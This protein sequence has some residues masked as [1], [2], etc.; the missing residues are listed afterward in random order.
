MRQMG[1]YNGARSF[2]KPH[3][4]RRYGEVWKSEYVGV[5]AQLAQAPAVF[6]R[7]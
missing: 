4:I 3:R 6:T 7:I 2:F 5:G 1:F